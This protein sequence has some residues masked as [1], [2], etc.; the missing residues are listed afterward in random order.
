MRKNNTCGDT[1]HKPADSSVSETRPPE[2]QAVYTTL[3]APR[4]PSAA[5]GELVWA[6]ATASAL[7]SIP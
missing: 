4:G 1:K 3:Q 2:L 5:V 6:G 7:H